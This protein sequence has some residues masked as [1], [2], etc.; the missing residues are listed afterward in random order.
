[1][2]NKICAYES[3]RQGWLALN[4]WLA[5]FGSVGSIIEFKLAKENN[6]NS[7]EVALLQTTT[8][9]WNK[10]DVRFYVNYILNK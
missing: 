4:I 7:V 8:A 1:M 3:L 5:T 9:I 10:L 2:Q 6:W